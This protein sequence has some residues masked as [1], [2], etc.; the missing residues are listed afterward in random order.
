MKPTELRKARGV[1][2]GKITNLDHQLGRVLGRLQIEGSLDDTF[3]VYTSDHGEMLG[4]YDD[5]AK[6]TFLEP[7]VNVPLIVRPQAA[8]G[9]E[10][11]RVLNALVGLDDLLPTLCEVAGAACPEDV[12]GRSWVP[13][14]TGENSIVRDHLHGQIDNSHMFHDGEYKYLYF[15]DDGTELLFHADDRLD[16]HNLVAESGPLERMRRRFTEH[17]ASENHPHLIDGRLV[18]L[19]TPWPS[20]AQL[21]ARNALGWPSPFRG[22]PT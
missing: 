22:N 12:T 6:R 13:L 7:S 5:T 19:N 2:Y 1:Y 3:I 14:L 18:N 9:F 17:L 21:R 11:G 10:P 4:D 20:E 15:A 8:M 16:A